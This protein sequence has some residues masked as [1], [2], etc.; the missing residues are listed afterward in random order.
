VLD[1]HLV[2]GAAAQV[3][4]LL[5]QVDLLQDG[6]RSDHPAGAQAGSEYLGD[7]AQVDDLVVERAQRDH[8]TSVVAQTAVGVVLD[9][10]QRI[11]VRELQ[12]AT[13]AGRAHRDA[14]RILE[15]GD[16]VEELGLPATKSAQLLLEEVG[17]NALIVHV[18]GADIGLVGAERLQGT[19]VG[20]PLHDDHI[21]GIDEYLA[22]QV[23]RLLGPGGDD[24]VLGLHPQSQLGHDVDEDPLGLHPAI[25]TAVLKRADALLGDGGRSGERHLV[26]GELADVGHTAGKRD[27]IATRSRREQVAHRA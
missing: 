8:M 12:Q 9:D 5:G 20:G 25:G 16:G 13:A 6:A 10:R 22:E 27:D 24:H 14:A 1:H 15:I 7:R 4:P 26:E 21:A 18:D 17:A 3:G 23:E 2:Q 19:Q 11:L